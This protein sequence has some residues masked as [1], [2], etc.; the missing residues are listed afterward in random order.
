MKEFGEIMADSLINYFSNKNNIKNIS[1]CLDMGLVF[2]KN[3]ISIQSIITNKL[4][5]F[6]GNLE[7]NSRIDA[8]SMIEKFGGKSSSSISSKTDY[9]VAGPGAGKKLEKAEKLNISILNEDEFMQLLDAVD[10]SDKK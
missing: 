7:K 4:F 5:V 10:S 9:V 8:I 1:N 3:N 6:T 2:S